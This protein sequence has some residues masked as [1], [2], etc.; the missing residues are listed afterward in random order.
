MRKSTR[1]SL[2][3]WT[4]GIWTTLSR[5]QGGAHLATL[6]HFDSKLEGMVIF[7]PLIPCERRLAIME[8]PEF[9]EL[10]FG[11]R[12]VNREYDRPFGHI[13]VTLCGFD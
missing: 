5:V 10:T 9:Q 8:I 1:S 2:L 13:S 6:R 4:G 12:F 7:G 3:R 11:A